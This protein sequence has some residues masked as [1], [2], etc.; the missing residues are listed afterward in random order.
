MSKKLFNSEEIKI[1]KS[2]PNVATVTSRSI[3]YTDE[4]RIKALEE[5]NGGKSARKIFSENGLPVEIIGIDRIRGF[6]QR[7]SDEERREGKPKARYDSYERQIKK[8]ERRITYLQQ[9]NEF[10]KKIRGLEGKK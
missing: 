3:Q 4:F 5:Y 7:L 8:L 6:F 9:E 10:L 1:L 2:N